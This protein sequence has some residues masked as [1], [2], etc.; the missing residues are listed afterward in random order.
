[1][2]SNKPPVKITYGLFGA[3]LKQHIPYISQPQYQDQDQGQGQGPISRPPS[4][5]FPYQI[6]RDPKTQQEKNI[7]KPPSL[8]SSPYE[9]L[10]DPNSIKMAQ[11]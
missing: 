3:L 8:A 2:S 4:N 6:I 9:R 5:R 1:M 7:P 10:Q 11:L